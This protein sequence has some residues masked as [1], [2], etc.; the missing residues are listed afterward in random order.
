MGEAVNKVSETV[1]SSDGVKDDKI[2]HV[3]L[4][5]GDKTD[6]A[7]NGYAAAYDQ[8][9][10]E[11]YLNT[12]GTDISKGGDIIT[13]LFWEAQRKDNTTNGLDLDAGQQL[14]LAS[15]R[16]EQAGNLWNR[17]SDTASITTNHDA[18][19]NW[20]NANAESDTLVKGSEKAKELDTSEDGGVVARSKPMIYKKTYQE[21]DK[22]VTIVV[23]AERVDKGDTL[24]NDFIE[25]DMKAISKAGEKTD[26]EK[27]KA[28]YLERNPDL[29]NNPDSLKEGQILITDVRMS[30]ETNKTIIPMGDVLINGGVD[31]TLSIVHTLGEEVSLNKYT[32]YS[33]EIDNENP[34]NSSFNIE[35]TLFPTVTYKS[36][37]VGG[38]YNFS[39][40]VGISYGRFEKTEEGLNTFLGSSEQATISIPGFSLSLG[41]S[42]PSENGNYWT[43]GSTGINLIPGALVNWGETNT[44]PFKIIKPVT[45]KKT[46]SLTGE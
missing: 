46:Y 32:H 19:I 24:V 18:V 36:E 39:N 2:S 8:N 40:N 33:L 15:S 9:S 4:Y 21:Y 1:Q 25:T 5:Q 26:F 31:A 6:N 38:G 27:V 28:M 16:G 11:T 22:K 44:K 13:S 35:T 7:M 12:E 45:E 30:K 10:N 3:N 42:N 23:T 29:A 34:L 17:F 43:S 20:N 37:V 14:I 41:K